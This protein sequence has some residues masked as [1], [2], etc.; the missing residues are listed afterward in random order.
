M[1]K[2]LRILLLS[3]ALGTAVTGCSENALL[4]SKV[5]VSPQTVTLDALGAT[6]Q[7][8]ANVLDKDGR[9]LAS[10]P[11]TWTSSNLN[12]VTISSSGMARAE[13]AGTATIR[14]SSEGADGS[15]TVTVDPVPAEVVAVAGDG[16][17]TQ[18]L[19]PLPV[20][21][22]AEVRDR[23]GNPLE[24]VQVAF[25]VT[26]GGGSV[27][28]SSAVTNAQGQASTT[29]T[30]GADV[31]DQGMTATTA[32]VSATFTAT[33]YPAPNIQLS[34]GTLQ[35]VASIGKGN[36]PSQIVDVT[37]GGGGLLQDLSV[38]EPTYQGMPPAPWLSATLDGT[39]GPTTLTVS[40]AA[41]GLPKGT[42]EAA[43]WVSSPVADNDPQPLSVSLTVAEAP[44]LDLSRTTL[45]FTVTEGDPDPAAE[46][47][48]VTN[49]GEN[50]LTDLFLE[51]PSY[52]GSPPAPW[53]NASLAGTE[54]PTT[55]TVQPSI[56]DLPPGSYQASLDVGSPVADNASETVVVN[57][58]VLEAPR[59]ALSATDVA[60]SGYGGLADPSPRSINVQNG[61]GQTLT[62]L[63]VSSIT[64]LDAAPAQ[65]LSATLAAGTAPTSLTL[66]PS[67]DG[68]PEGTF[69]A[70]VEID[71]P[72]ALNAPVTVAVTLEVKNGPAISLQPGSVSVKVGRGQVGSFFD[73]VIQN[74][75]NQPLT[76]LSYSIS[77]DAGEPTGWLQS[78]SL[79]STSAPATLSMRPV[80]S[81]LA[82]GVYH[83]TVQV[84]TSLPDV[85]PKSSSVRL[86]VVPSFD[87]DVWPL[88]TGCGGCHYSGVGGTPPDL[89]TL[90]IA[91]QS[92]VGS[93]SGTAY[94]TPGNPSAGSLLCYLEGSGC[95]I[96]PPAPA[97]PLSSSQLQLVRDWIS[98]G[99]L[100]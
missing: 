56:Q 92:L 90:V 55:L 61:G 15:A 2:A 41:E 72:V 58:T 29:W 69:A 37:N 71:S 75:G 63:T 91:Y 66:T 6:H 17:T 22:T 31:G 32:D 74:V 50:P 68:L 18:V 57:L 99:A 76:G 93:G 5:E 24:G 39:E 33:A 36:P 38:T 48:D 13:G 96:M 82:R 94:V 64:Y 78:A 54:A 1:R 53:L 59:I 97:S 100:R 85:A 79:S 84:S 70:D 60:F 77:Y 87:L 10:S 81:G 28:S 11:I 80:A 26:S 9:A 40:V 98:G 34:S 3:V 43:V 47:V 83:G 8:S 49:G 12:V 20:D 45:D 73:F 65:W 62:G 7:F 16:Q 21:P 27:G 14:A 89:S 35:F 52:V 30:L 4:P 51:G 86:E 88:F 23:L 95:S 67:M 19:F 42:Y 44:V 46:T 25:S